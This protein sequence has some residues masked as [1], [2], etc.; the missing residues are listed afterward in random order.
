MI[1]NLINLLRIKKLLNCSLWQAVLTVDYAK[2]ATVKTGEPIAKDAT[3]CYKIIKIA[4]YR[5]RARGYTG[6]QSIEFAFN[7]IRR[8]DVF[9]F[10]ALGFFGVKR[11]CNGK[12][13]FNELIKDK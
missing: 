3:E 12:K 11:G 2:R 8:C 7:A 9:S 5:G 4:V 13:V 6:M 1:I 10:E